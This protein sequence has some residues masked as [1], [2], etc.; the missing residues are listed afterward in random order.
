MDALS[1]LK[2]AVDMKPRRRVVDLPNGEQ[3]EFF[4]TPLTLAERERAQR[5]ASKP[6]DVSMVL[7][8]NKCRD[9]NGQP[10]F[11]LPQVIEMKESL[12]ADLLEAFQVKAFV[13]LED[14]AAEVADKAA[15]KS[16]SEG[17]SKGRRANASAGDSGEAG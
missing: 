17:G 8:V 2:L 15:L 4:T 7:L 13:E 14:E 12:P 1:R 9:A 5:Q 11:S 3:F 10:H 6:E 16:P